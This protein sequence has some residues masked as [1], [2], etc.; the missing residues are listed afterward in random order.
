MISSLSFN[1]Y[2]TLLYHF[3]MSNYLISGTSRGLGLEIAQR[4][5]NLP[6][7]C[8]NLIFAT[9]RSKPSQ[10]FQA[11][12]EKSPGRVIY[13]YLDPINLIGVQ[14]ALPIIEKDIAGAG[15]DVLINNVG[16]TSYIHGGIHTM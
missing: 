10:A 4:L 9:A 16:A 11:L 2:L 15:L 3:I 7:S 13:I 12:I 1:L 5:V 8:V 14:P 6:I